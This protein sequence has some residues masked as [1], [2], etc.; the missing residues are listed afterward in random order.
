MKCAC[1]S[2]CDGLCMYEVIRPF[3]YYPIPSPLR[4]LGGCVLLGIA[5]EDVLG[6]VT[7]C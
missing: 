5:D 6:T 7:R 1:A 4:H 2:Q 3:G